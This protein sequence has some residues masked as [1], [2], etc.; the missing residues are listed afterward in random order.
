MSRESPMP[1]LETLEAKVYHEMDR[2][3]Q[4]RHGTELVLLWKAN[5]NWSQPLERR[6]V[7]EQ[8]NDVGPFTRSF[9]DLRKR[10]N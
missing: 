7:A 2:G 1:I 6:T 8:A 10:P 3:N 4:I 9:H 5:D